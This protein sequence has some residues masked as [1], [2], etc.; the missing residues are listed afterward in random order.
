VKQK[1][2]F[3]GYTGPARYQSNPVGHQFIEITLEIIDDIVRDTSAAAASL[4]TTKPTG[5]A[6]CLFSV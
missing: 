6:L 2:A 3:F 5:A 4:T 1:W